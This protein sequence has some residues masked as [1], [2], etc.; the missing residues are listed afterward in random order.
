MKPEYLSLLFA[1]MGRT[2]DP[3]LR[4]KNSGENIEIGGKTGLNEPS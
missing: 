4:W 3:V 1:Y 2:L